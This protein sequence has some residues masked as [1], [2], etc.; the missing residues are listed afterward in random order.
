MATRRE[1]TRAATV[2]EIKT[3]A[4]RLMR[5]SGSPVVRFTE[6]AREMGMTAPGLYRYFPSR[7]EL[8][9]ALIVDAFDDL[10]AALVAA[11]DALPPHDTRGRLG[12][13]C[14][15][16]RSWASRERERFALLFGLPVPG[17][18]A[19]CDGPTKAAAERTFAP[20]YEVVAAG[21]AY[22]PTVL[23]PMPADLAQKFSAELCGEMPADVHATLLLAWSSLHGFTCLEVYGHF[24]WLGQDALDA[25]FSALQ[26]SLAAA[27]G[28]SA[29]S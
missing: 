18:A 6:I 10:H 26:Q 8:L 25:L 28:L 7:D 11:R 2:D 9:T 29:A 16:Y 14:Q 19:P 15:A 24:E 27:M 22:S 4:L 21:G 3:T 13:L 1:I 17:F 5:D 23:A 12:A 20:F